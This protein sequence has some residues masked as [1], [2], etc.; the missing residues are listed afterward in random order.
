VQALRAGPAPQALV[1]RAIQPQLLH[2]RANVHGS[3]RSINDALIPPPQVRVRLQGSTQALKTPPASASK[4][5]VDFP[6][7]VQRRPSS[8]L[9]SRCLAQPAG[10]QAQTKEPAQSQETGVRNPL[11]LERGATDPIT[12]EETVARHHRC[13]VLGVA[14]PYLSADAATLSASCVAHVQL[15]DPGSQ[16]TCPL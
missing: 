6:C 11:G 14:Q 16:N 10:Q 7:P 8:S 15:V 4:D 12:T 1:L 3:L 9:T 2:R 5:M 13:F